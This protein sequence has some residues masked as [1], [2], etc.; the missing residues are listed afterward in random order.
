[1]LTLEALLNLRY[2][3]GIHADASVSQWWQESAKPAELRL[4]GILK[5]SNEYFEVVDDWPS[6]PVP[7][8]WVHHGYH[9]VALQVAFERQTLKPVFSLDRL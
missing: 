2:S 3:R 7:Y 4:N 9:V 1:V 5:V 8:H 6:P